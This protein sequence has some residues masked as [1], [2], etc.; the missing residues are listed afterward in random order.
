MDMTFSNTSKASGKTPFID[1]SERASKSV[2]NSI[3]QSAGKNHFFQPFAEV[4][5]KVLI[6]NTL[7]ALEKGLL[8]AVL[9]AT[10]RKSHSYSQQLNN[11]GKRSYISMV[12]T[13]GKMFPNIEGT[14][15]VYVVLP[16]WKTLPTV[17]FVSWQFSPSEK[18]SFVKVQVMLHL[19]SITW[20]QKNF[21]YSTEDSHRQLK[22]WSIREIYHAQNHRSA[23]G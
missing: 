2:D 14:M 13:V 3:V 18:V 11:V 7:K 19:I 4:L 8:S 21:S 1:G 6:P 10:R 9:K 20:S 5:R 12:K 16:S 23:K 22:M 15:W 17:L